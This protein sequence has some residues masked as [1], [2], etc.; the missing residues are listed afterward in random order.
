M[1]QGQAAYGSRRAQDDDGVLGLGRNLFALLPEDAHD[2]GPQSHSTFRLVAD[3]RL[4]NRP[5]LVA[6]LGLAAA[7]HA[8][9][10][11]AALLFESL[12]KWG[13]DAVDH[14][15]G[16]FAFAFWDGA[17]QHLLLGRDI[18]GLRPLHFHQ[19]KN[20]FA[21]ASMPSGLHALEEVPY[22]FDPEFMVESLALIPHAGRKS[23][24]QD[25]ERVEPA[26]LVRVTRD[27]LQS[28]RYWRPPAPSN[29]AASPGN[30]EQG[31][32]SVL[33]QAVTAQLRGAGNIVASHL[34][35]GL[36]S[37]TVT[38]TAARLLPAG[39]V[40]AFTAVPRAGFAG[41]TPPGSIANEAE[42]AAATARLYPNIEHVLVENNGESP[43][44][45]LDRNF[46]YHQQ[47]GASL[48]NSVWGRA[49][50]RAAQD[51]GANTLF[52][53]VLGN[54]TI[55][56]SG[57]EL[58]PFLLSQGRLLTLARHAFQLARNGVP[59]LALGAQTAG[60]FV[61][62]P[63][64]HALRRLGGRSVGTKSYSAVSLAQIAELQR[65]SKARAFD[66][67]GRP[68]KDPYETRLWAISQADGGNSYKGVLAEWGLSVRDPTA[69][70]R[71][72]EFCLA[73]PFEEF[74]RGGVP[75]S[76]ARRAFADRLPRE[77]AT[78]QLRGYQAADWHEALDRDRA[79]IERE[80]AAIIRCAGAADALDI[81]WLTDALSAWPEDGWD[82]YEVRNRYRSGLL[83]GISAGYFMRKVRGTN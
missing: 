77:V 18:L 49:I 7:D 69:D 3:V 27:G 11:D 67:T 53:G 59:L 60:H 20:F 29:A 37:S 36:D 57:L 13:D 12:L 1:L 28:H 42:L 34:S 17:K 5:E 41:R 45:G 8:R 66:M 40:I 79:G 72:I 61:P 31:L 38:A 65:K 75:R 48:S 54:L 15:V 6:R 73:T 35:A 46:L 68:R 63:L 76:L 33:D 2:R 52:K 44:A 71:V 55:S 56:Y 81:K 32:R 16:E 4:D 70:K 78:S 62:G 43:L 30:Y 22:D 10:P 80:V 25:I 23:Y 24:F 50:N 19:G 74:V 83:R 58:L 14:W 39:R 64:W 9:L 47:P 51:R 26:H 21:F 82:Q